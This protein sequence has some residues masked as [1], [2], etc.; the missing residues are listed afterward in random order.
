MRVTET[1]QNV[2]QRADRFNDMSLVDVCREALRMDGRDVPHSR[3][4]MIRAAVSGGSLT[5]I[6]TTSVNAMLLMAYDEEPDSPPRGRRDRRRRLQD[7]H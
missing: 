2:A 4:E 7:Q 3:D 6:F 1:W 5:Q